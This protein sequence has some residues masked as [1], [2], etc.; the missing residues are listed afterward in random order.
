MIE[1]ILDRL[2]IIGVCGFSGAGKTTL[3]ERLVPLLRADGLT[4]AVVKHDTHGLQVDQPGK[5]TDRLFNA[6]ATV[7]AQG[8]SQGFL[9]LPDGSIPSLYDAIELLLRRH[10][11]VL[12]EGHR[13]TPLPAKV[14]L[15]GDGETRPP[16]SAG[17]FAAILSRNED[18][19]ARCHLYLR[20]WLRDQ[21]MKTPVRGGLL[22]GGASSRM[23]QPK[24]LLK[25]KGNTWAESIVNT[26]SPHVESTALLGNSVV[27]DTLAHLN[28]LRDVPDGKGPLAGMLSALRWDPWCQWLFVACDMPLISEEAITW[29][30][31]KRR[32]GVWAVLPRLS[33]TK[34]AEPLF[35]V[36]DWRAAG[37]L[38][39]AHR[40]GALTECDKVGLPLIPASLSGSWCNFNQA[41]DLGRLK[42]ASAARM[43]KNSAEM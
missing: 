6:G 20:D 14:W 4:V 25:H 28:C 43:V 30:L 18:R 9:R 40:P 21:H 13:A 2:P 34:H 23:G 29:L 10:D 3:I 41:S 17:P 42:T 5:D 8:P 15:Q 37:L 26:L 33:C 38:D 24:H 16:E 1:P 7:L 22:F 31:E 12:V 11:I 36:Y 27:P 35:A 32:A 19:V 39:A